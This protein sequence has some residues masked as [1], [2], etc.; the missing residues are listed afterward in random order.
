MRVV[1]VAEQLRRD[2]PGGIGTYVRGLVKGL[3]AMGA[4]GPDLA[5]WASRAPRGH[6]DPLAEVGPTIASPLPAPVLVG[7]WDRGWA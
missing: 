6:D 4:A 1:V 2:V 7:A 3:S 5:L